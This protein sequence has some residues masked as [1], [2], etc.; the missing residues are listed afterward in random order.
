[1]RRFTVSL[2]VVHGRWLL[3]CGHE[4]TIDSRAAGLELDCVAC[5]RRQIPEGATP[6]RRTPLFTAASTP[7]AFLSEHR[8]NAWAVLQVAVGSVAFSEQDPPWATTATAELPITIVPGRP[9]KVAAQ[10]DTQFSAQFFDLPVAPSSVSV[11]V[12]L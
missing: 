7:K 12:S 8:T 9:H 11:G 10:N 6:G 1:V 3:D 4:G 2:G 5:D